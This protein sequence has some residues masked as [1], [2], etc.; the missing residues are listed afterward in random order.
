[1]GSGLISLRWTHYRFLY[2][3]PSPESDRYHRWGVALGIDVFVADQ[4]EVFSSD[5]A[6]GLFLRRRMGR[7]GSLVSI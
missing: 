1:M 4:F 3:N 7:N 2:D 5:L 6:H